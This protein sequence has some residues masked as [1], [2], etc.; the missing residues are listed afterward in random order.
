[1]TAMISGP[2]YGSKSDLSREADAIRSRA[3]RQYTW[4]AALFLQGKR[5]MR[6]HPKDAPAKFRAARFPRGK[7]LAT[8]LSI[9]SPVPIE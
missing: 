9:K 3:R 1:M 6:T 5:K 7:T 8:I 2:R 4:R